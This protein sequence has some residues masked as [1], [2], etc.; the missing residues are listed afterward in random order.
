[1]QQIKLIN[2][3]KGNYTYDDG[4]SVM[5]WSIYMTR[6]QF[7]KGMSHL[8]KVYEEAHDNCDTYIRDSLA[9]IYEWG[10]PVTPRTDIYTNDYRVCIGVT[11]TKILCEYYNIARYKHTQNYIIIII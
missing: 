7:D 6:D 4:G 5:Y 2:H 1:M 9:Y 10:K 3:H 11:A 8:K